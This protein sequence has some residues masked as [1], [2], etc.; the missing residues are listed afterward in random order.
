MLQTLKFLTERISKNPD[1]TFIKIKDYKKEVGGYRI[2][3]G[4]SD[5]IVNVSLKPYAERLRD[6]VKIV[7]SRHKDKAYSTSLINKYKSS[8]EEVETA[9]QEVLESLKTSISKAENPDENS[10]KSSD[11]TYYGYGIVQNNE[12]KVIYITGQK[13]FEDV[14]V[15]AR[16]KEKKSKSK[17][18]VKNDISKDLPKDVQRFSLK[19]TELTKLSLVSQ[20]E[21]TLLKG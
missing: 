13:V 14:K 21:L 3:E 9:F 5:V 16:Y 7:E 8:K 6:S 4:L 15:E 2:T 10:T 20:G 12:T 17:T 18:L 1:E 19:E 11:E